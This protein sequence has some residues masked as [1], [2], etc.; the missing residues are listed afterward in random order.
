M[1]CKS[2][3]TENEEGAKFCRSCGLPIVPES[4]IVQPDYNY[5]ESETS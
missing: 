4:E 1:V 3:G 5:D 2:C